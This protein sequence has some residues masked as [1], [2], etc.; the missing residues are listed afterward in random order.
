MTPRHFAWQAWH[1][2]TSTFVSH[3]RC[4]TISH[5]RSFCVASVALMT[6]LVLLFLPPPA[7][8][9]QHNFVTHH[10]S[11][12]TFTCNF[13]SQ[14]LSHTFFH[15]QLS[16]TTLSHTI[17]H[18]PS[19]THHFV[20]HRLSTLLDTPRPPLPPAARMSYTTQLC[21]TP[22][23]THNFHKQLC[24]PAS[25]TDLLSHTTFTH[26]FVTH[27]LSHPLSHTLLSHTF[28]NTPSVT[29]LML[30][31]NVGPSTNCLL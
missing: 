7:C 26:N 24:Q 5:S 1:L 23:F 27:H 19:F 6:L 30:S 18:T 14:H 8:H 21:H 12:T 20:T 22:S 9:T 31:D 16:H 10:L 3:G 15:T 17:F 11:H 25:F 2:V 13:V 29:S 4:G 28:F